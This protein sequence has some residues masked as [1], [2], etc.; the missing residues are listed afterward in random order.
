MGLAG[1]AHG[2]DSGFIDSVQGRPF[3]DRGC[4]VRRIHELSLMDGI[5]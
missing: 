4:K 1:Q 5:K 3:A 2:D